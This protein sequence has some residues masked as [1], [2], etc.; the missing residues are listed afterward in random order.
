MGLDSPRLEVPLGT[1]QDTQHMDRLKGRQTLL[2]PLP[3][4]TS[5]H[6]GAVVLLRGAGHKQVEQAVFRVG[7]SKTLLPKPS[8]ELVLSLLVG[9]AY[10]VVYRANI[11]KI[12]FSCLL[13]L[14]PSSASKRCLTPMINDRR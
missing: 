14:V 7:L 12:L 4:T 8:G 11:A 6:R 10:R 13:L 3:E 9:L 2:N 5:V 1:R